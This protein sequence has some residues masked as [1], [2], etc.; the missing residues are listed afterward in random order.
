[1][2]QPWRVYVLTGA[3]RDALVEEVER[4]RC[5]SPEGEGL[6][7]PILPPDLSETYR[8]RYMRAGELLYGAAGVERG[9]AEGR[10]RH[11]RRGW[12]FFDAPVAL[13][14]TVDRQMLHGQWADVGMF[15]QDIM[16]LAR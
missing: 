7:R 13:I 1:N 10:Y 8:A 4:S 6:G 9:D 11:R 15:V 12:R 3:A 2:L 5:E 14:F 16:L